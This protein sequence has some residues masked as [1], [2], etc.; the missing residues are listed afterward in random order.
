[1]RGS[2]LGVVATV[3]AAS[4]LLSG[5]SG[6]AT[7]GT[8]A[9]GEPTELRLG[10]FDNLTHAPAL[11]GIGNGFLQ[12]AL[13]DT[14]LNAQAFGAGPAAIEALSAGAIDAAY[15]G[16]SPAVNTFVQSAGQSAVIVAGATV[17]G[18][19]LVVRAGIDSPADLAGTIIA[20]PQLGNTQDVA[21]RSW[22]EG[23]GFATSTTGGG[24][25]TVA[26]TDNA[27]ALTLFQSGQID[28]AWLPEP[29][30]SRLVLEADATVLVDEAS[31]WDNG[32]FPTTV[33]LV[34]ADFNRDHPETVRALLAGHTASVAW[35]TEHP[36]EAADVINAKLTA[37][38]GKP[39]SDAVIDRALGGLRFTND[40]LA[41]TFPLS[42]RE[43]VAAGT[44][45]DG[46][47]NGLFDL[48]LLNGVL[49]EAGGAP[50]SAAGLGTE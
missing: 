21:L 29:W 31:L 26:P 43:A 47:L 27:R 24:D 33:L 44:A 40:P 19:A 22:L 48:T 35:L 16:P 36:E 30:V 5:C 41:G 9:S 39:L 23:E 10:Y 15:V 11:V 3:L 2:T 12:D 32:D 49:A 13:G 4:L 45:K 7:A 28:G 42:H 20:S 14:T 46:D 25:V 8:T 6:A 50:I 17:G 37:D 18:A 38:T 34:G 1:M